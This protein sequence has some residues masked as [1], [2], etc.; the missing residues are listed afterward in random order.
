ML[1]E[2]VTQVLIGSKRIAREGSRNEELTFAPG[3]CSHHRNSAL[4]S[5]EDYAAL[6]SRA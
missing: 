4:V 6:C 3:A 5:K 1:V 2:L